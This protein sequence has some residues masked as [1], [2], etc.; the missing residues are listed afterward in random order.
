MRILA[1]EFDFDTNDGGTTDLQ[2]A[3]GRQGSSNHFEISHPLNSADDAH[4]ISLSGGQSVGFS[5]E[6]IVDAIQYSLSAFNLGSHGNPSTFANYEAASS[7]HTVGGYFA[8]VNK[9]GILKTYIALVGLIGVIST[10]FTIRR[11]RKD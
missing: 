10:I 2:I 3:A 9:I 1:P 6:I 4:D 11:W 5:F 8:P 7:P